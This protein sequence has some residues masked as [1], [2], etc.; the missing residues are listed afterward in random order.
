M[1]SQTSKVCENGLECECPKLHLADN[2][3]YIE[4]QVKKICEYGRNC[5]YLISEP[6]GCWNWHAASDQHGMKPSQQKVATRQCK[7]D[8]NCKY[9]DCDRIH[10]STKS[11]KSPAYEFIIQ[12]SEEV[13]PLQ[14]QT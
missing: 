5:R 2:E 4:G 14:T 6:G 13:S 3:I 10:S 11:G 7:Y 8:S 1:E 9:S 12:I